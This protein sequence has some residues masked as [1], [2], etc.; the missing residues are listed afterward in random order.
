MIDKLVQL[1][2]SNEADNHTLAIELMKG[3]NIKP[4]VVI[5]AAVKTFAY[6]VFNFITNRHK[7]DMRYKT[8]TLWLFGKGTRFKI[9]FKVVIAE[10]KWYSNYPFLYHSERHLHIGIHKGEVVTYDWIVDVLNDTKDVLLGKS[11]MLA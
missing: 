6:E 7:S 1:A 10:N 5:D 4:S 11:N 8:F 9:D 3:Q 2:T